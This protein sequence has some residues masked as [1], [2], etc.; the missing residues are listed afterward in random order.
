MDDEVA[1][2][3]RMILLTYVQSTSTQWQRWRQRDLFSN[4]VPIREA[5]GDSYQP[6]VIHHCALLL[7][8]KYH[9]QKRR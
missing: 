4:N 7:F 9:T 1:A 5:M 8:H 2:A 6:E 3:T